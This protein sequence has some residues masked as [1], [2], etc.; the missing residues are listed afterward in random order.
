MLIL[1]SVV[2]DLFADNIGEAI[3]ATQI[4]GQFA[5]AFGNG[6]DNK[7]SIRCKTDE[8]PRNR[9]MITELWL[10]LEGNIE[11][12]TQISD[13]FKNAPRASS[14]CSVAEVDEVGLN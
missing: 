9:R 2:Q 12:D 4:G 6:V 8:Q 3:T 14:R 1:R 7:V 11:S 5:Q 13:L 10:N